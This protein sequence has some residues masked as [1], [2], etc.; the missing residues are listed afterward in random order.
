MPRADRCR[1]PAVR[2]KGS[3]G[4]V[5]AC[6]LAA[7][8]VGVLFVGVFV[9]KRGGSAYGRAQRVASI[10]SPLPEKSSGSW[11]LAGVRFPSL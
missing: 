9:K 3:V 7:L 8:F 4:L 2:G 5:G 6:G 10:D 11:S 1:S